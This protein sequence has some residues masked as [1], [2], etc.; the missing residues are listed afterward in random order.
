MRGQAEQQ[1]ISQLRIVIAFG[2]F[3]AVLLLLFLRLGYVQ[4]V[5]GEE[6]S[7]RVLNIQKKDQVLKPNRGKI[8]DRNGEELAVNVDSYTVWASKDGMDKIR[9]TKTRKEKAED[10]KKTKEELYDDNVNTLAK[11]IDKNPDEI[12]KTL[13]ENK[14]KIVKIAQNLKKEKIANI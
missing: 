7:K 9:G 14:R 8:L 1:K 5:K 10:K 2:I 11:L 12:K 13:N 4:I 3:G 6:Y